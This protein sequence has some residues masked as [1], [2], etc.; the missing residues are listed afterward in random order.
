MKVRT[1]QDEDYDEILIKWWE[2]WGFPSPPPKSML[3]TTG[4]IAYDEDIP[5]A[6]CFL[7]VTNSE[8]AWV[9]WLVSNKQYRKKPHRRIII[10]S[11]I[12]AVCEGARKTG[13][14]II[15]T[16]TNNKSAVQ[17]FKDAGFISTSKN[18]QELIKTWEQN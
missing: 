7:Y 2:D 8:I 6:A 10:N 13:H 12:E 9:T 18:T 11:L 16:A 14:S 1:I 3:P 15:Y 17:S 5:V 4:F